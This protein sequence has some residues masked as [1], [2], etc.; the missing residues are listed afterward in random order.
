[1]IKFCSKTNRLHH[2]SEVLSRIYN[3]SDSGMIH[4]LFMG[5]HVRVCKVYCIHWIWTLIHD[6][7][8][9][10]HLMCRSSSCISDTGLVGSVLVTQIYMEKG[11]GIIDSYLSSLIGRKKWQNFSNPDLN[12]V[13]SFLGQSLGSMSYIL[14]NWFQW[15]S[16]I[17]QSFYWNKNNHQ[18]IHDYVFH[19]EQ[20]PLYICINSPW[21]LQ[22]GFPLIP[23][24]CVLYSI[25]RNFSILLQ[26]KGMIKRVQFPNPL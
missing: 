9:N 22:H 25:L 3:P 24:L 17:F 21:S 1:M 13:R 14:I 18:F 4:R 12:S 8:I 16:C 15:L 10:P 11:T 20:T 19:L 23:Q 6:Q 26:K 2:R 5:A 7:Y